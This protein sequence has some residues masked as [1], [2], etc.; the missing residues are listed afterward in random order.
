VL[1]ARSDLGVA[2]WNQGRYAEAEQ[3]SIVNWSMSTA[4]SGTDDPRT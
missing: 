1:R 4:A 3:V 2:L